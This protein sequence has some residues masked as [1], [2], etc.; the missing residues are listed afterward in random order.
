MIFTGILVAL[1]VLLLLI[2][3]VLAIRESW[4]LDEVPARLLTLKRARDRLMRT[5]KDLENEYR[6]GSLLESDYQELRGSVKSEAV[7]V[8]REFQK[9]RRAMIQRVADGPRT[10]LDPEV[11]RELESRVAA[12]RATRAAEEKS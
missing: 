4:D 1:G 7:E 9:V 5:L 8:T 3:P 11:L 6:E 12:F 10:E 2:Y